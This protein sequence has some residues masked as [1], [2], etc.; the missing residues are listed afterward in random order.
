MVPSGSGKQKRW[1]PKPGVVVCNASPWHKMQLQLGTHA[2]FGQSIPLDVS[3]FVN[4]TKPIH[5]FC[6]QEDK[7]ASHRI[8]GSVRVHCTTILTV[9]SWKLCVFI[10]ALLIWPVKSGLWLISPR[11]RPE[12]VSQWRACGDDQEW[13]AIHDP[14]FRAQSLL[15]TPT[16]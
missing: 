15:Q 2:W 10:P 7:T 1:R 13:R 8:A 5:Y 12:A 6:P 14:W 11:G 3:E 9:L 4:R 16:Y